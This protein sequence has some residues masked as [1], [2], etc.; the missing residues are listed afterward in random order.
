MKFFF[1]IFGFEDMMIPEINKEIKKNS[2][3]G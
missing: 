3:K 1:P 2:G